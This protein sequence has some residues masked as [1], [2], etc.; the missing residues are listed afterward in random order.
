[1]FPGGLSTTGHWVQ[2]LPMWN[3][4]VSYFFILAGLPPYLSNQEFNCHFISTLNKASV[5]EIGEPIVQELKTFLLSE[6]FNQGFCA[7]D[8]SI[9]QEVLFTSFVLCFLADSPMHAEITDTPVP[10]RSLNPCKQFLLTHFFYFFDY[11]ITDK[12]TIW[13]K[14]CVMETDTIMNKFLDKYK[15]KPQLKKKMKDLE[16]NK[17]SQFFNPFLVLKAFDGVEDT[18][19]EILHIFLLGIVKYLAI[20]F[21]T[22]C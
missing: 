7:F 18:P 19:G 11:D 1:M 17:H 4:H 15:K 21:I 6:K 14:N 13:R 16:E 9:S 12:C 10:A 3:K 2:S 5:L 22:K 8:S 20:D